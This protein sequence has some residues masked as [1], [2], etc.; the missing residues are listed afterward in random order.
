MV[1]NSDAEFMNV[2]I[3]FLHFFFLSSLLLSTHTMTTVASSSS[4][5]F[6]FA[7]TRNSTLKFEE[8]ISQIPF[9]YSTSSTFIDDHHNS[10]SSSSSTSHSSKFR[11]A[12]P[13]DT[14]SYYKNDPEL[15]MGDDSDTLYQ[16]TLMNSNLLQILTSD[17][18]GFSK[19]SKELDLKIFSSPEKQRAHQRLG[20]LLAHVNSNSDYKTDKGKSIDRK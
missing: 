16:N 9:F 18:D 3:P 1:I 19:N 14:S 17:I 6:P 15:Y 7:Q 12:T 10:S 11:T 5:E 4:K 20:M 13:I 8:L 2:E